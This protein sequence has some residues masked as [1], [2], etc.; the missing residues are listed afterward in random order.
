M[1]IMPNSDRFPLYNMTA[2]V[3]YVDSEANTVI[4][5]YSRK[6]EYIRTF[7][8]RK[9]LHKSQIQLVY[10][11]FKEALEASNN[12]ITNREHFYLADKIMFYIDSLPNMLINL[13][14]AM[15]NIDPHIAADKLL[16]YLKSIEIE[17][18]HEYLHK[19]TTSYLVKLVK[20]YY[21]ETK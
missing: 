5:D 7:P 1:L 18:I 2:P 20:Q 19:P 8:I 9:K 21:K 15:N 10:D 16:E 3:I 4:T 14:V 17:G 13:D 12:N 11:K 6:L